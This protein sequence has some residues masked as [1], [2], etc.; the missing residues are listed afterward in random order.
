[1]N[2]YST[3]YEFLDNPWTPLR[4]KLSQIEKLGH[5]FYDTEIVKLK[6]YQY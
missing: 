3:K 5:S 2:E 1:M 4:G 6:A